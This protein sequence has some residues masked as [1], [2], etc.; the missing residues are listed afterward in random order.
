ML[1]GFCGD[2]RSG[3]AR[4]SIF[5]RTNA[6]N[7]VRRGLTQ[8]LLLRRMFAF[9][10]ASGRLDI[11]ASAHSFSTAGTCSSSPDSPLRSTH[12]SNDHRQV[13]WTARIRAQNAVLVPFIYDQVAVLFS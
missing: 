9:A 12:T 11:F 5:A 3:L 4:K 2:R 7:C 10:F 1:V 6:E 13:S 8:L